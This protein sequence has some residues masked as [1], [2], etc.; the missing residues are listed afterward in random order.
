MGDRYQFPAL[1]GLARAKFIAAIA[2]DDFGIEGLVAAIDVVYNTTPDCDDGLRKH[3]VF[4]AQKQ[5][6]QLK[7]LASFKSIFEKYIGFSWDFGLEYKARKTVWCIGCR[8]ESKLPLSCACGF[9]GLCGNVKSCNGLEWASLKCS[10]C[11]RVGQLIRDEP[12]EEDEVRITSIVKSASLSG[13]QASSSTHK[14]KKRKS[15]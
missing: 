9:H 5:I 3:G 15:M 7:Q 1:V 13:I 12:C 11:K 14:R 4:A 6:S 10:A 8:S 2:D